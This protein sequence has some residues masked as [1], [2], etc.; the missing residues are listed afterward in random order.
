MVNIGINLATMNEENDE[1]EQKKMYEIR[2]YIIH[3]RYPEGASKSD[4]GIIRKRSKNFCV[5]QGILH[6]KHKRRTK[7]DKDGVPPRKVRS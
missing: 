3:S 4:K 6:Y 2:E 5:I 1:C 7:E